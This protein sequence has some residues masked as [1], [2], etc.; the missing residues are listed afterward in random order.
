MKASPRVPN[1]GEMVMLN[2]GIIHFRYFPNSIFLDYFN[3]NRLIGFFSNHIAIRT[4]KI[5]ITDSIYYPCI[6][7]APRKQKYYRT[8]NVRNAPTFGKR[9]TFKIERAQMWVIT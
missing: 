8:L 6:F 5:S 3:F 1:I 9:L 2:Y 7:I 4:I